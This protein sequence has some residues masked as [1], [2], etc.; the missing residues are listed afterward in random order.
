MK[1]TSSFPKMRIIRPRTGASVRPMQTF[2]AAA[3]WSFYSPF[4]SAGDSGALHSSHQDQ[5]GLRRNCPDG[6]QLFD[7]GACD[8]LPGD[9]HNAW[10]DVSGQA[11]DL[12]EVVGGGDHPDAM[13][14]CQ[15]AGPYLADQP[16]RMENKKG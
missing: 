3:R 5:A 16:L 1:S 15:K 2:Y 9:D 10:F 13:P 7:A 4:S 11:R 12:F 6:G 8:Q 14:G